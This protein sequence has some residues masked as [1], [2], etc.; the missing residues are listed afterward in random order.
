MSE[1]LSGVY[2]PAELNHKKQ[3]LVMNLTIME[4]LAHQLSKCMDGSLR[5]WE[6]FFR[7]TEL[8]S[9]VYT[10]IYE[11]QF[12]TQKTLLT[13]EFSRWQFNGWILVFYSYHVCS[14][15]LKVKSQK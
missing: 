4:L 13:K 2:L 14:K 3:D 9:I 12:L 7:N 15:L 11:W 8:P 10:T 5:R 6:S 1:W